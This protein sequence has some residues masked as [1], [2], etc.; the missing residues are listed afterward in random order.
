MLSRTAATLLSSSNRVLARQGYRSFS[1]PSNFPARR[2]SPWF[3]FAIGAVPILCGGA[4][5]IV[6]V[7][8]KDDEGEK[9]FTGPMEP[10]AEI[11]SKV[12]LDVAID[13]E[14]A[15]RIVVGLHGGVV[16][17]TVKNFEEL[18]KTKY[19]GCIFHRVVPNFVIQVRWVC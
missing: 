6:Y 7:A 11:T 12:F 3:Y 9:E 5:Y 8:L 2:R 10:Q 4:V 13:D 17:K 1:T 19:D 14:P 18:A 16:P 15:G